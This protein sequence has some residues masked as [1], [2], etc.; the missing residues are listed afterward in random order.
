MTPGRPTVAELRSSYTPQKRAS[1]RAFSLWVAFAAR[2]VSFHLTWLFVRLG[3]SANQVTWLG[4]VVALA[5]CGLLAAGGY[6]A[7][8]AGAALVVAWSV[9]DTVDG[10][11]ARHYGTAGKR[12]ELM[13]ALVG[14]IVV[15]ALFSALGVGAFLR[16]D[17]G[18]EWMADLGLDPRSAREAALFLGVWAALMAQTSVM[19][20]S[21]YRALYGQSYQRLLP[22]SN[23]RGRAVALAVLLKSLAGYGAMAPAVLVG[24]VAGVG[25]L[26]AV[27]YAA[28]G[29]V[30]LVLVTA[31][32]ALRS[33][34]G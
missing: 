22:T 11:L 5:G 6:A 28:F 29:T 3:L 2:P 25:S 20:S 10:N 4:A 23:L 27:Y 26:V 14:Y 13:D 17:R 19:V 15:V 21:R 34:K 7:Q 32:T 24:A 33:P 30:G 18:V 16:P 1:D 8:I 12:G 31:T 9:L